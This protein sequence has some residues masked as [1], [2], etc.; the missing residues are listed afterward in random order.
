[1]IGAGDRE[2][3]QEHTRE[4]SMAEIYCS[5]CGTENSEM[6]E[7]CIYCGESLQHIRLEHGLING[8]GG[9]ASRRVLLTTALGAAGG[10]AV[11]GAGVWL[12]RGTPE[13]EVRT[14]EVVKE[15]EWY[16]RW[17]SSRRCR[18]RRS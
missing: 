3:K 16:G 14:V 4:G 7:K 13:P 2:H 17:R 12:L 8:G 15:V 1:M 10:L 9:G 5:H 18:S 11:G 6:T